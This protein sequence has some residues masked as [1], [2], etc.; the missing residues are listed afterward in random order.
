VT[1]LAEACRR[2]GWRVAILAVT[3][4][5]IAA[6]KTYYR[7][8]SPGDLAWIL[9]PTSWLVSLVSGYDFAYVAG[10]GWVSHEATFIIAPACAGIHFALAALLALTVGWLPA[11]R[12]ARAASAR[13]AAGLTI[14]LAATLVVNTTRIA[15]AIALHRG[16]LDIGLDAGDVHR[17]EGIAIYLGGLCLLAALT[18]RRGGEHVVVE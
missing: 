4:L 16:A 10:A 18:R 17:I 7:E 2:H 12:D 15:I 9:A 13:L 1:R 6:A 14:A 5:V 11:V 3:A 8:A